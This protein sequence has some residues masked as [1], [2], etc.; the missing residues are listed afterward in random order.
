MREEQ[1]NNRCEKVIK[2]GN[3]RH[4]E[5]GRVKQV[6]CILFESSYCNFWRLTIEHEKI[7]IFATRTQ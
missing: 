1:C 6:C 4:D 3:W 2:M 5:E 7:F